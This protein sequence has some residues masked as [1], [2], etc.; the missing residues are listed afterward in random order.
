MTS[1]AQ[2][3]PAGV[4][5]LNKLSSPVRQIGVIVRDID[6]AM[7][8]WSELT[9]IGPFVVFRNVA[10]EDDYRYCGQLAEPPVV[11]LA[12]GYSGGLQFELIQQLNDAPSGY[13]DYLAAGLEGLQHLSPQFASAEEYDDAYAHL[14]R[15][16]LSLVHEGRMKGTPFRF[17]YFSTPRGGFPQFEISEVLNPALKPAFDHIEA[18]NAAW[19]GTTPAVIE[20]HDMAEMGRILGLEE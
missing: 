3:W 8:H 19:D 18:L 4:E 15:N 6:A 2:P 10:L 14:I 13:R 12:L 9:G 17:A 7:R 5:A 16:G 20:I 1:S 11:D